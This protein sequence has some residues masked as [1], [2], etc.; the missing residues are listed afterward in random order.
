MPWRTRALD[1]MAAQP[2]GH[3]LTPSF[4][5]QL[6]AVVLRGLLAPAHVRLGSM[7]GWAT[8]GREHEWLCVGC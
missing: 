7:W 6:V 2:A 5:I 3:A 4:C 1:V 8:Q